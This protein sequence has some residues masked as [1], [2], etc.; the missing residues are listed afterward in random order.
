MEGRVGQRDGRTDGQMDG[1][2]DRREHGWMGPEGRMDGQKNGPRAGWVSEWQLAGQT[3][4][5]DTGGDAAGG[6]AAELRS[7]TSRP[8]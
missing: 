4:E 2:R 7:V 6:G 3:D 8:L 5:Q 1:I